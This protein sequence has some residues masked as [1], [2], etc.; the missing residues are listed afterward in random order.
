[1]RIFLA[2]SS[3]V[4]LTTTLQAQ[5]PSPPQIDIIVKE[6]LAKWKAP[7]LAVAVV[8]QD[9]LVYLKGFGVKELGKDDRVTPDTVFP[10]AS[11][12]KALTVTALAMLVDDGKLAWD[13]PV[14]K[15]LPSFKLKDPCADANV[16]LRDLLTHRTGLGKHEPLWF[17]TPWTMEERVRRLAFLEPSHSFRSTFE[18]Q[19]I[20]Y[21]AA[22]LA[23]GQAARS[24]WQEFIEKRL[25]TPLE[26]KTASAVFPGA[27]KA[28]F[29]SPHKRRGQSIAVL[30]R[31]PLEIPDPAGSIHA[32]ARDLSNFL[33]LQ[34]SGGVWHGNNKNRR[35]VEESSLRE[36]QTPQITIPL[37]EFSAVMNPHSH[38]LCYTLGWIAQDYRGRWT[39]MHGGTVDGF[40]AQLTL[41]PDMQLGIALLNN[42]DR[43]WMNLA[44]SNTLVDRFCQLREKDWNDYYHAVQV[45][46]DRLAKAHV[47][48]MRARQKP[49]TKP[50]LPLSSY[51]GAYLDPAYGTCR[52]SVEE[53]GL[54]WEWGNVRSRLEHF[55]FDTF[56]AAEEPVD[57]LSLTFQLGEQGAVASVRVMERTFRKRP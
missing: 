3:L 43:T 12:S 39:L 32:S 37:A 38:V 42:L 10:L 22:G 25:F 33:R 54:Y 51:A 24:T 29:A 23:G 40:R 57:T 48:R 15:H 30:E 16:T 5:A 34:L 20:A 49:N 11:C 31:Y 28:D 14:R 53:D 1:M 6:A 41:V 44:L 46:E 21:G 2:A 18:Y 47:D 8:H 27:G 4:A 7:G 9:R 45:E 55:H 35:L 19:A 26:M 56:L 13:D 36:T 50:S 52:I 17:K